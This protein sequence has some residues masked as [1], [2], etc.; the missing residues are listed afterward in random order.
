METFESLE[1]ASPSQRIMCCGNLC[2]SFSFDQQ[3]YDFWNEEN[4]CWF[5]EILINSIQEIWKWLTFIIKFTSM[6]SMSQFYVEI[7]GLWFDPKIKN[8]WESA[9]WIWHFY[10]QHR[11]VVS[12]LLLMTI[13]HFSRHWGTSAY[14]LGFQ[15][16]HYFLR[17]QL[18]KYILISAVDQLEFGHPGDGPVAHHPNAVPPHPRHASIT[19]V[20]KLRLIHWS[21]CTSVGGCWVLRK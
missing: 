9:F 3:K 6:S 17:T 5:N 4:E 12:D 10:Y 7:E 20:T 19:S 1:F 18:Q 21:G 13:K 8:I 15:A 2:M 16:P 11:L 14:Y